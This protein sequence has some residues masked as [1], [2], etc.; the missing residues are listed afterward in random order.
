MR[1]LDFQLNDFRMSDII[2]TV[3]PDEEMKAEKIVPLVRGSS[4]YSPFPRLTPPP[5]LPP[6]PFL[7]STWH[8][9]AQKVTAFQKEYRHAITWACQQCQHN[10]LLKLF[11]V[12]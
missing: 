11:D 12:L 3:G 2:W 7:T 5:P 9:A 10:L 1:F 8:F 4:T 6:I